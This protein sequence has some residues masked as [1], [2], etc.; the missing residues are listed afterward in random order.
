MSEVNLPP[1]LPRTAWNCMG[2][3]RRVKITANGPNYNILETL[4][5]GVT[6]FFLKKLIVSDSCEDLEEM[7]YRLWFD[8]NILI[9]PYDWTFN[10]FVLIRHFFSFTCQLLTDTSYTKVY[11]HYCCSIRNIKF[12]VSIFFIASVLLASCSFISADVSVSF[13]RLLHLTQLDWWGPLQL[14]HLKFSLVHVMASCAWAHLKY[15]NG[16]CPKFWRFYNVLFL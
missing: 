6:C 2:T 8:I 9:Q 16:M 7:Q 12:F 13:F 15:F 11:V 14:A 5:Q 10:W 1:K 3:F 4:W